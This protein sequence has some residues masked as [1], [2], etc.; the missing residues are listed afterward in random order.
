MAIRSQVL[1]D[2]Q[3]DKFR[4]YIDYGTI[5]VENKEELAKESLVFQIVSYTH[6]FK[7]P[8]AYF[9][10][11]TINSEL[12]AQL[13]LHA[14]QLLQEIGITVR[15]LTCDGCGT[16]KK[17]LEILGCH[18]STKSL[19]TMFPHPSHNNN[20]HCIL[21]P[22]HMI[23]LCRNTLAE[24]NIISPQGKIVLIL[25]KNYIYCKKKKTSS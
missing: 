6:R 12:Q 3:N 9:F 15:S 19:K 22:S 24:C 13:L 17:T 5:A 11:N 2:V 18:F 14:I 25:F 16:N 23:K 7:C 1:Y 4:E 8:I 10:I 21:D 20:I